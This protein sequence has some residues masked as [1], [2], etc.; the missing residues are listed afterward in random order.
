MRLPHEFDLHALEVFTLTAE[1]GGMTQC[2][3]HLHMTQSAVSQT[4]ARLE[5]GIGATLFDRGLRPLGLTPLG[6]TLYQSG[7]KLLMNA[8]SAYEE[9]RVGGD[10]PMDQ[11]AIGMAE[12]LAAQLSVLILQDFGKRAQR[13]WLRSGLSIK[14][15]EVFLARKLDMLISGSSQLEKVPGIEHHWVSN[16]PFFIILPK[17]YTGSLDLNEISMALPFIR[18]ALDSGM[19]QQIERQIARLKLR[20]P[21]TVEVDTTPQQFMCVEAGLGWSISSMLCLAVQTH[22]MDSIRIEPLPRGRFARRIQVIARAGEMGDLPRQIAEHSHRHLHHNIFPPLVE[23]L[24]WLGGL[25]QA[26]ESEGEI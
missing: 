25:I 3:E 21:Q 8:K 15:H 22:R 23:R 18:Y 6:R 7:Q 24:S 4:I 19:G 13:W 2:A 16:D 12:S 10:L 9:M 17:S 5:N 14:Q 26:E 20:L 11:I 1:L